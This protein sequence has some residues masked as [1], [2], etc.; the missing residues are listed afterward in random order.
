MT[1][2]SPN[3]KGIWT[4]IEIDEQGVETVL[5]VET[6]L[7]LN[8]ALPAF[9]AEKVLLMLYLIALPFFFRCHCPRW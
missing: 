4:T 6:D 9:A 2:E 1:V 7:E 3:V 8:A 5:I